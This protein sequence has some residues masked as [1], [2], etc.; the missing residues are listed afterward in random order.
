MFPERFDKIIQF[1]SNG[2][3][4]TYVKGA[5][6]QGITYLRNGETYVFISANDD[7]HIVC[8]G[9]VATTAAPPTTTPTPIVGA[10]QLGA[11]ID[12]E[13]HS[14][15]SGYSVS[16]SSD[17]SRIAIGAIGNN[18]HGF[19]HS[20]HVRIYDWSGSAWTQV[21]A[22][23]DGSG[24]SGHSV[25]LSG[26]GSRVAIG[27]PRYFSDRGRAVIYSWNG[28]AWTQ[29][30]SP[31]NGQYSDDQA[32]YSVSL[33]SDGT[34]V[35]I[36]SIGNNS[37]TGK[38]RIYSWTGSAWSQLGADIRGEDNV[39]KSGWSVSLSSDGSRVAIGAPH[40]DRVSTPTN[41]NSNY[42]HVRIYDWSGSS[43]TQVGDDI[44]GESMHDNS[45]HSVSL[46]GDGSRV[47]I[48]APAN[49]NDDGGYRSGHVR[50][51]EWS[52]SAWTQIGSDI[53]GEASSD[54]SGWSVSLSSDGSRIAIGARYNGGAGGQ[55]GH[56][57]IYDWLGADWSQV[58]DDIDG[59]D[60]ADRSGWSVSLSSDGGRVAIGAPYNDF[61]Y[62]NNSSTDSGHVRVYQLGSIS[63]TTTT[64]PPPTLTF[65]NIVGDN[66]CNGSISEFPKCIPCT[67]TSSSHVVKTKEEDGVITFK[68]LVNIANPNTS[69][70]QYIWEYKSYTTECVGLDWT[71]F[72]TSNSSANQ[73]G[74]TTVPTV[75]FNYNCVA[76]QSLRIEVRCTALMGWEDTRTISNSYYYKCDNELDTSEMIDK[77]D[78]L[79]STPENESEASPRGFT[80]ISR[81]FVLDNKQYN[82]ETEQCEYE[83]RLESG[84]YYYL[85][86][87]SD[88]LGDRN[89]LQLPFSESTK[90]AIRQIGKVTW[91]I[92]RPSEAS[93]SLID[94]DP[95]HSTVNQ[96]TN[97]ANVP[98]G[99][100]SI[101]AT[102][103]FKTL[104]S[105]H[106]GDDPTT[107]N[108][109]SISFASF[110]TGVYEIK[111]KV[112]LGTETYYS[113]AVP[114][115][116][117]NYNNR[118]L[119]SLGD[120]SWQK[121]CVERAYSSSSVYAPRVTADIAVIVTFLN[122]S[123][124]QHIAQN[125]HRAPPNQDR[126]SYGSFEHLFPISQVY[127]DGQYVSRNHLKVLYSTRNKNDSDGRAKYG[128][129]DMETSTPSDVFIN[130]VYL[131]TLAWGFYDPQNPICAFGRYYPHNS[132]KPWNDGVIPAL[133]SSKYNVNATDP[134]PA[135]ISSLTTNTNGKPTLVINLKK[136]QI[137]GSSYL[138]DNIVVFPT[139]EHSNDGGANWW[140]TSYVQS[141]VKK[142][143]HWQ[144]T[145]F[146]T[147][148]SSDSS[149]GWHSGTILRYTPTGFA[150]VLGGAYDR[151]MD[152]MGAY[153]G[154]A[155]RQLTEPR[156][157]LNY[158]FGNTN[159][160]AQRGGI[161]VSP[162]SQT[163]SIP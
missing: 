121:Y 3:T 45:G 125:I 70:L 158:I 148:S 115:F 105:Y 107:L 58:G 114:V 137:A 26:D 109:S 108:L 97:F 126:Q 78:L 163:Y 63:N 156:V 157:P 110:N 40:N 30:G 29:V 89:L 138:D 127:V 21:G 159:L 142:N 162:F 130:P 147:Y 12:G 79:V 7:D 66:G 62:Y 75:D 44:D 93:V 135:Q 85:N 128:I 152:I 59:E 18:E 35:A 139:I 20:G 46:S 6:L 19:S 68:V 143:D 149:R 96:A 33:S 50:V 41:T 47:A 73:Y 77:F 104:A 42:G 154:I 38:V 120:R 129:Q 5:G 69:E 65:R 91:F 132:I 88:R 8:D 140:N 14:D 150:G 100:S 52:G 90:E 55:A 155:K 17:G 95:P 84:S 146:N 134:Y 99:D 98:T 53:D 43:W 60:N 71:R 10:T 32:G 102:T 13:D 57:R 153:S 94:D 118:G 92:R 1:L 15:E 4:A 23:I 122:N 51:Y 136:V 61:I 124:Y 25:S 31:I 86:E 76:G 28:V 74:V 145:V 80:T 49:S 16:L 54:N 151:D 117:T 83:E 131:A 67:P 81:G 27:E 113:K 22:D 112:E 160:T 82:S 123:N 87:P 64:P 24:E 141:V 106:A 119:V 11:D 39:D 9:V 37:D 2:Q 101:S 34:K 103:T 36:G 144:S 133:S 111:A 161:R 116:S 56:V 48:G 72:G